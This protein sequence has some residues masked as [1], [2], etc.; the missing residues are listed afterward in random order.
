M[1]TTFPSF[2]PFFFWWYTF[3]LWSSVSVSK[4]WTTFQWHFVLSDVVYIFC[5]CFWTSSFLFC[6]FS[7]EQPPLYSRPNFN[8]FS[9]LWHKF[10][11]W[12]CYN[13]EMFKLYIL[14]PLS[15]HSSDTKE[16][17]ILYF[18]PEIRQCNGCLK[19]STPWGKR[20][21]ETH[22]GG[23]CMSYLP[24]VLSLLF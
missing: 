15:H 5:Y 22:K 21:W 6:H 3:S 9:H 8:L 2:L 10:C 4:I 23:S 16:I 18:R 24:S 19:N 7:V 17:T 14:L 11:S 13:K 20:C 1:V 12:I